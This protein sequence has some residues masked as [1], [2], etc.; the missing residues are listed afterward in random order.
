MI[1]ATVVTV[2]VILAEKV[3]KVAVASGGDRGRWRKRDERLR[4]R[5]QWQRQ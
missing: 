1:T 3:D 4:Q 2:T 5:Q